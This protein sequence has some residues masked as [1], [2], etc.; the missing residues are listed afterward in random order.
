MKQ[1]DQSFVSKIVFQRDY[2]LLAWRDGVW[3]VTRQ[4]VAGKPS[5]LITAE[6][7]EVMAMQIAEAFG[8]DGVHVMCMPDRAYIH[9]REPGFGSRVDFQSGEFVGYWD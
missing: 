7:D 2:L 5:P 4:S 6:I 8:D 1:E 3:T 9:L